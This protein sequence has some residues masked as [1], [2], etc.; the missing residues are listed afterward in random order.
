MQKRCRKQETRSTRAP[1]HTKTKKE[2]VKQ[3]K[4]PP[5]RGGKNARG[6]CF[7][8]NLPQGRGNPQ[9]FSE[10]RT[11]HLWDEEDGLYR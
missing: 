11:P 6:E 3:D 4:P 8:V 5:I 10:D 1:G 7:V 9:K 2:R